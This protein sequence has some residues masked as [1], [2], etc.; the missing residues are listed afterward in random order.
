MKFERESLFPVEG[1][2]L[3]LKELQI[4]DNW[5]RIKKSRYETSVQS[6]KPYQLM[7]FKLFR[8]LDAVAAH[9]FDESYIFRKVHMDSLLLK[10]FAFPI[11]DPNCALL[12]QV[13]LQRHL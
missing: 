10:N 11:R 1:K 6:F 4:Q 5:N 7:E 8:T 2:F 13:S 12:F 3:G 9:L